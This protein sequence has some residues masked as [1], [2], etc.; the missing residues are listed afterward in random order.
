[1]IDRALTPLASVLIV[2]ADNS[3]KMLCKYCED[4]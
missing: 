4:I 3:N 2:N 1:M